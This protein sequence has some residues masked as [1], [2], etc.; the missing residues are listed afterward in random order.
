MERGGSSGIRKVP[1]CP[2]GICPLSGNLGK[3]E[4]DPWERRRP[5]QTQEMQREVGEVLL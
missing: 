1:G 4:E 5:S 3:W 2:A